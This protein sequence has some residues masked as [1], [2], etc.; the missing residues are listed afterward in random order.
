MK[1]RYADFSATVKVFTSGL[2]APNLLNASKEV[3]AKA[4]E[5]QPSEPEVAAD[6][7]IIE[8]EDELAE[9]PDPMKDAKE[10]EETEDVF[11]EREVSQEENEEASPVLCVLCYQVQASEGVL[12]SHQ[13]MEHSG[14]LGWVGVR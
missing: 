1:E 9:Q 13:E 14:D 10:D 8:V 11:K 6:E 12:K 3:A 2:L 4:L 7:E 5:N